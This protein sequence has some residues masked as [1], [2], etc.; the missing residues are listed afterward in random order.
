MGEN[1]KNLN[2]FTTSLKALCVT[3]LMLTLLIP[4]ISLSI[5]A[6]EDLMEVYRQNT[7]R[8]IINHEGRDREFWVFNPP[9]AQLKAKAPV[10]FMFHGTS[11]NGLK[12]YKIS[13]WKEKAL[14]EG[15]IAVFPSALPYQICE[16]GEAPKV[17]T[18]WST[19]N[20]ATLL[21]DPNAYIADDQA[22]FQR[23]V[24]YLNR[25]YN[26]NKRR[27]YASGFSNG[28]G[29]V[30]NLLIHNSH[31]LAAAAGN[32]G[33]RIEEDPKEIIPFFSTIGSKDG[34]ALEA[35]GLR[36]FPLDN[37][38]LKI[39]AI[40]SSVIRS[41]SHLGLVNEFQSSQ[42]IGM[43]H[44]VYYKDILEHNKNSELHLLVIDE[45]EHQYPNGKNH[46]VKMVDILWPFFSRFSK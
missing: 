43:F 28:N 29:F 35:L 20:V 5:A 38:Y 41:L 23:M 8:V 3:T 40:E 45:L 15:F 13:Q 30:Q 46:P 25:N 24:R 18:K 27:I 21:C 11:G 32:G 39:P 22:F 2:T 12:F 19:P 26:V 17:T 1:M 9:K 6:E 14:E 36:E 31:I 16:E 37:S 34:K 4:Q 42:K 7:Q 33:L 44:A 10:V